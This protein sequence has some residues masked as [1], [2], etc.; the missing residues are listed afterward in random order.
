MVVEENSKICIDSLIN[1]NHAPR[2][3]IDN[4]LEDIKSMLSSFVSCSFSWVNR[5]ANNA[6]HE[7]A[8]WATRSNY[9]GLSFLG[10]LICVLQ[11]TSLQDL[12]FCV[13]LF[14]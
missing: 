9:A 13:D 14:L 6:V 12:M 4:V 5:F 8:K 11:A 7:L 2:W 10:I 3:S 1:A